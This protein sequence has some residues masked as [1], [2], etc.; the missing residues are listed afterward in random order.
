MQSTGPTC[1][2]LRDSH[3]RQNDSRQPE[4]GIDTIQDHVDF[5]RCPFCEFACVGGEELVCYEDV[6]FDALQGLLAYGMLRVF[7]RGEPKE[8]T[9]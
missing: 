4:N 1:T 2:S 6:G 9:E 3:N 8:C 5:Q 7:S